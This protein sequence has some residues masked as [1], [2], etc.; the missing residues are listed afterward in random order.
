MPVLVSFHTN[1][2]MQQ[3]VEKHLELFPDHQILVVDNNPDV[4]QKLE[5]RHHLWERRAGENYDGSWNVG[6]GT[7]RAWLESHPSLIVLKSPKLP[8]PGSSGV[9]L[10]NPLNR[11]LTHGEALTVAA[12][13]LR[14]HSIDVMLAV[15]PDCILTG[16]TW[17]EALLEPICS[18]GMW[19]TYSKVVYPNLKPIGHICPSMWLLDQISDGFGYYPF[20]EDSEEAAKYHWVKGWDTG[21]KC[22]YKCHKAGK[23]KRILLKDFKHLWRGSCVPYRPL[24]LL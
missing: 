13:W 17:Y 6:C 14:D 10:P 2:W 22:W 4:G 18:E 20:T 23:A 15:E 16:R 9:R 21:Q 8:P 3:Y 24:K 19:C 1:G 5:R 7:E 11:M 12:T